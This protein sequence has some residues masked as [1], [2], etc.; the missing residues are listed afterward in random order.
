MAINEVARGFE[1]LRTVRNYVYHTAAES[2]S[3]LPS[4]GTPGPAGAT[5]FFGGRRRS[6]APSAVGR[7]LAFQT[8]ARTVWSSSSILHHSGGQAAA[9]A[10]LKVLL[11]P[12]TGRIDSQPVSSD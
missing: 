1:P 11:T 8:S 9:S 10:L 2:N 7:S 5:T 4:V 3:L 6:R 12:Q